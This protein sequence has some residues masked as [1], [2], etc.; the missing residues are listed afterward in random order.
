[1]SVFV[2]DGHNLRARQGEQKLGQELLLESPPI[3]L[4]DPFSYLA[5]VVRGDLI[6]KKTDLSSIENNVTVVR[7]LEAARESAK[8]GTTI[9]F[10]KG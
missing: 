5:A 3:P 4:N 6:V 1:M 2:V 10:Q 9:Y 7:I 8:N